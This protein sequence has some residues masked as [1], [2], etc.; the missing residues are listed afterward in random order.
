MTFLPFP[1]FRVVQGLLYPRNGII[2]SLGDW[3][4]AD[5]STTHKIS[6]SLSADVDVL[7][8]QLPI[9]N[10]SQIIEKFDDEGNKF[11]IIFHSIN[12]D[13]IAKFHP[14]LT[15]LK[16]FSTSVGI[17]SIL[18][19]DRAEDSTL[20]VLLD[21][22]E[23][24]NLESETLFMP[25]F[26]RSKWQQ[27]GNKIIYSAEEE[28]VYFVVPDDYSLLRT[29][30]DLLWMVEHVIMYPWV[31]AHRE[32]WV[33]TR[34]PGRKPGLS[35]SGGVDSTAAMCLMPD[36]CILFYM[37]RDF[38]SM[39]KHANAF[40]FIEYLEENGRTVIVTKSNH[41]IIRTHHDLNPG[42]STD[43][44]CMAH[45]IL[46][47]DYYDL[48]S[49][50]TG[51]P[52]ENAYFFH[53]SKPRDFS[54]S[55]FWKRYFP[56]FSYLGIPLFQPVA[57]CSEIL[58]NKIVN[59]NNF[60]DY[61]TSCLRSTNPGELCNK[62]WKCFRKNTFNDLPWEMSREISTFLGKRPLK[63]GIATLYALQMIS[64]NES[65]PEEAQDLAELM[66]ENFDFLHNYWM[67]SL[68]LLPSKYR[69]QVEK[70]LLKITNPMEVDIYSINKEISAILRGE[71]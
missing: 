28:D 5:F 61:A 20:G 23:E 24:I 32:T 3:D 38:E 37:E 18:K 68:E 53:G 59:E 6:N 64:K 2:H 15:K 10:L 41:E 17:V 34:R 11:H 54:Q 36:D 55:A 62:C 42:F 49:A 46:L 13:E 29:S 45:L 16:I 31:M 50:G 58:N 12:T 48:D 67:P 7:L 69:H 60:G 33:P 8:V 22:E 65:I 66:G 51:M 14:D 47:A 35:F 27:E 70:N 9:E 26:D 63:Q 30:A 21:S 19:N 52:L 4:L 43:Y 40:R 56:M 25:D 44:A 1:V 39:L 57:G 71:N